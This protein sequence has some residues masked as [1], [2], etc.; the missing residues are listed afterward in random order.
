MQANMIIHNPRV[1]MKSANE[2]NEQ[3]ETQQP[4][5]AALSAE[6][7]C[8]FMRHLPFQRSLPLVVVRA[9]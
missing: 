9:L 8:D 4:P 2:E 5:L 7:F 3:D 6:S 1:T